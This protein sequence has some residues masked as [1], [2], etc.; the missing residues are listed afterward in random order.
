MTKFV[1]KN[2][3]RFMINEVFDCESL[4]SHDYYSHHNTKMFDM[5]IDEAILL[6][7]KM[8]YPI[9]REMDERPPE[10]ENG[11]VKVH[12]DVKKILAEFGKGGWI[13]SGFHQDHG[14][15]QLPLMLRAVAS[16]IFCAA[17]Y[18]ATAYSELTTGAAHLLT[19]F[20]SNNLIDTY[21]P[22]MLEGK[23]QGT[24]ALT[25][26]QAGSSLGDIIT[27]AEPTEND[28]Y[29]IQGGKVFISAGAHDGA[30]NIVHLM[31][32]RIKG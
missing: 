25:E 2:N 23:W 7:T 20:A 27:S 24:M 29:L 26:P 1:S 9:L 3:I 30:D 32:V 14:G 6:G 12:K 17:N 28:W 4:T 22:N 21:V 5:V 19:S 18:G 8:L 15:E 31:L 10:L 13:A 16:F 11:R